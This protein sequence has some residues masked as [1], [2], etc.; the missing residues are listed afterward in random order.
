[1][2]NL[3]TIWEF[4]NGAIF[5]MKRERESRDKLGI[6]TVNDIVIPFFKTTYLIWI[7]SYE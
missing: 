2:K 1:M 6:N 5:L 3:R 7:E 4:K